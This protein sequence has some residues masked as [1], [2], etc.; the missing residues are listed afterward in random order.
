LADPGEL[1][2]RQAVQ[3]L[4][5]VQTSNQ[6]YPYTP[7]QVASEILAALGGTAPD[8]TSTA[9][10]EKVRMLVTTDITLETG[11]NMPYTIDE[12]AARILNALGGQATKDTCVVVMAMP[13]AQG[14]AGVPI[15]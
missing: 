6:N 14:T 5:K 3:I 2:G 12:V 13:M 8:D 10:V 9:T 4:T 7:E 1:K 15:S 11:D